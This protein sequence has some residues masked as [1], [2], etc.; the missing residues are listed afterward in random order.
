MTGS[1]MN[2]DVP[3]Y[4]LELPFAIVLGIIP[5]TSLLF[6]I[7]TAFSHFR[8]GIM[9]SSLLAGLAVSALLILALLVW[10]EQRSLQG[11]HIAQIKQWV[12]D[13]RS[14]FKAATKPAALMK[15]WY[16]FAFWIFILLSIYLLFYYVFYTQEGVIFS[17]SSVVS[18][19]GP[20]LANISSFVRGDNYAPTD[21]PVYSGAGMRYHFFFF[22]FCATLHALGLS[23]TAALNLA[24]A[25]GLLAFS[26][27]MGVLAVY[28]SKNKTALFWIQPLLYFQSSFAWINFLGDALLK[29]V[30][31]GK[32]LLSQIF[33]NKNFI[34]G[35]MN[36]AWGLWNMNVYA[37]Q[38]HLLF[39]F[40]A[41]LV[42]VIIFLPT[43]QGSFGKANSKPSMQ[44][45]WQSRWFSKAAWLPEERALWKHFL[46]AALILLCLPYWHGA[47]TIGL[48][49]LLFALAFPARSKLL[50]LLAACI[51]LFTSLFYS[52][53]FAGG[54]DK[55]VSFRF[56]FGF[57]S[58]DKSF[59]GML[60]YLLVLL[61]PSF[62]VLFVMPFVMR[63]RVRRSLCIAAV[64]PLV[65]ALSVSLTP[66]INVNHK[67]ILMTRLLLCLPLVACL[68]RLWSA[69]KGAFAW[70]RLGGRALALLLGF[71][72]MFSGMLDLFPYL[73]KN[74]EPY[75]LDTQTALVAWL[76]K[77]TNERAIFLTPTWFYNSFFY[78]G[79]QSWYAYPYYAWSA[80]YNSV[81]REQEYFSLLGGFDNDLASFVELINRDRIAYA[82]ID[83][84]MRIN[85]PYLN[86]DFF[87]QNFP[88]LV[89]FQD[90][91]GIAVYDLRPYLED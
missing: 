27:L 87:I 76:E 64:L 11:L 14:R 47:V 37:N 45:Y 58:E 53:L 41:A 44:N 57:L 59:W 30:Y 61:G 77:N 83:N 7:T 28:F 36:D 8:L 90:R 20:H 1:V 42:V 3:V 9:G 63:G 12:L 34:G 26:M 67:Y 15:K 54:A 52:R 73:N 10:M 24:S 21:Y 46:A 31:Q 74:R 33:A 89:E 91:E 84:D 22:F 60:Q 6:F 72:L 18:D 82:L 66:D 81:Q 55:V 32:S 43:L 48:L 39:A 79:R 13:L 80:G 50:Y 70:Q 38:R 86:E 69:S 62:P 71:F 40:A 51:A 56:Q 35:Q 19:Y 5:A 75:A 25:L 78:T 23:L 49:L 4:F 88:L 17:G 85:S 68:I 29:K 65:F 16:V 2:T